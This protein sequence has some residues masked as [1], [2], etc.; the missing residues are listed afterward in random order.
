M[1]ASEDSAGAHVMLVPAGCGVLQGQPESICD[2]YGVW[3]LPGSQRVRRVEEE[4]YRQLD[5][6]HSRLRAWVS[7]HNL[8]R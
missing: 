6:R 1:E 5:D 4:C 8:L 7:L 2:S 3:G